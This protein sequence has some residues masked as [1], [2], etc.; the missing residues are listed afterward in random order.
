MEQRA[1]G[2]TVADGK[3]YVKGFNDFIADIYESMSSIDFIN[4]A[5]AYE[6]NEQL[7]AMKICAEAICM[8][9]TR[10]SKLATFEEA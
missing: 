1:P 7:K 4:D 2:H 5:Q 8:L 3:I 10:Y 9:G 6:K